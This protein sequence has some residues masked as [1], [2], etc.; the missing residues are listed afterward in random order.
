MKVVYL[1]HRTPAQPTASPLDSD[2]SRRWLWA[3]LTALVATYITLEIW[4]RVL[5]SYMG[6]YYTWMVIVP[7]GTAWWGANQKQGWI[8]VAL[9]A[10]SLAWLC[11]VVL[12][13]IS[14]AA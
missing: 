3:Y 1:G 8:S 14:E 9:A 13:G 11:D 2:Y 5:P 12:F 10:G 4:W 6:M 7:L